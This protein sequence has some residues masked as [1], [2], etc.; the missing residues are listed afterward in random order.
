MKNS[1]LYEVNSAL[2][3]LLMSI[4]GGTL[5]E[6]SPGAITGLFLQKLLRD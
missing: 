3:I 4:A 2:S 1:L 5:A 6:T